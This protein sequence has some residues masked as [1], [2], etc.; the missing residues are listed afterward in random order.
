MIQILI[1]SIILYIVAFI[2]LLIKNKIA[3][4]K[5]VFINVLI[6]FLTLCLMI[7]NIFIE[8]S[9]DDYGIRK[10]IILL[11][12]FTLNHTVVELSRVWFKK[13]HFLF[14]FLIFVI[15]VIYMVIFIKP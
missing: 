8:Y 5:F 11:M 1:F 12:G 7:Y 13:I 10:I 6:I 4:N 3:K 15:F 2:T 9:I 14:S